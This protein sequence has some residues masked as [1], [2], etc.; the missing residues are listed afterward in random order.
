MFGDPDDADV[1]DILARPLP[2]WRGSQRP[3]R[4]TDTV[5]ATT[6]SLGVTAMT[7]ILA[8]LLVLA[9][10][11]PAAAQETGGL[12]LAPGVGK[13]PIGLAKPMPFVQPGIHASDVQSSLLGNAGCTGQSQQLNT[14]GGATLAAAGLGGGGCGG[15][16]LGGGQGGASSSGGGFG[17]AGFGG[18]GFGGG[19]SG[20]PQVTIN[21]TINRTTNRT[22][23][24]PVAFT[25]G[26]GNTVQIQS[27]NGS[28]PIALQQ[29]NTIGGAGGNNV[30]SALGGPAARTGGALR[31][32]AARTVLPNVDP[33]RGAGVQIGGAAAPGAR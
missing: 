18:G 21:K 25:N 1:T 17:G 3:G 31:T 2:E 12:P 20:D 26:N 11:M 22:I 24:G 19:G 23:N 32:P 6:Q 9:F 13:G 7:R 30:N 10:A 16:G 28:G 8:A 29:V 15:A 33:I 4:A 5:P 27:A 14:L